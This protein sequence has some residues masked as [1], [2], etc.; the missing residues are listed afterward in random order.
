MSN[1]VFLITLSMNIPVAAD[2]E[3]EAR[4]FLLDDNNVICD[5]A[6]VIKQSIIEEESGD[7]VLFC[8]ELT[9][10][11]LDGEFAEFEDLV[12]YGDAS[13]DTV[14]ERVRSHEDDEEDDEEN[15]PCGW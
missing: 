1:R 10:E 4:A 8:E 13:M 11:L 9:E 2:S 12:P 7:D 15:L 5:A 14:G 6:D 3:E